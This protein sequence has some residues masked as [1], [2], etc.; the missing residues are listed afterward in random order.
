MALRDG[1]TPHDVRASDA[2]RERVV[3]FLRDH[4][5]EGRLEPVELEERLERA[6]AARLRGELAELV[7]DLPELEARTEPARPRRRRRLS[8]QLAPYLADNLMLDVIW[9]ATGAGYFWPIWPSLGWGLG[10]L[11]HGGCGRRPHR[12]APA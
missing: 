2:E 1:L 7:G 12:R 10:L 5:A 4:A 8:P 6:Y 3:A 11:P 9:A